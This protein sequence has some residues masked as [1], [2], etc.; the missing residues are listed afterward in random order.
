[1]QSWTTRLQLSYHPEVKWGTEEEEM[2]LSE[3]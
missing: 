1:M 3:H 2:L